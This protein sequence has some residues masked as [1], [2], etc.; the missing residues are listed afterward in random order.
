MARQ[1][2]VWLERQWYRSSLHPALLLLLPL[3]LLFISLSTLR[4]WAFQW[5]LKRTWKAPVPVIVVGNVTVGGTGKTPMVVALV[6][7][8]QKAGWQPGIVSRGYGGAGPFPALVTSASDAH[9]VGD[10]PLLLARRCQVPLAVAPK[11]AAAAQSLLQA[12]PHVD[13]LIADDGLQHLGLERDIEIVVVDGKRGFGNGWRLPMGPLRET[14]ARALQTA[15]IVNNG[16]AVAESVAVPQQADT[17][18]Y[19]MHLQPAGWYRVK[20]DQPIAKPDGED[21]VAVAAIGH[22]QRFFETLE[23]QGIGLAETGVFNDHHQFTATDFNDFNRLK[24]VVMTEKDAMKCRAFAKRHW[25]Y[26]TVDAE[27]PEDFWQQLTARLTRIK[28][29]TR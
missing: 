5:R 11:R 23:Q 12:H 16:Q 10:E 3:N 21:V 27:L 15:F 28:N 2:R 20:D 26:L 8:L 24:P 29:G 6:H 14:K 13:V 17:N 19:T 25:Y 22:P 7:Q 4:R 9:E 1:L 18:Q